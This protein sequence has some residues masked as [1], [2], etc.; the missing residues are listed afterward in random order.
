MPNTQNRKSD[1]VPVRVTR[2][3][4]LQID[5]LIAAGYGTQNEVVRTAVDR[6]H[7]QVKQESAQRTELTATIIP[8][9]AARTFVSVERPKIEATIIPSTTQS[10]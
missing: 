6:M 9:P 4:R 7:Q 3:M 2:A 8:Q 10:R 5:E 1:V